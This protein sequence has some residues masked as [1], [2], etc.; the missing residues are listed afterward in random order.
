[1]LPWAQ[2]D[3]AAPWPDARW[4]GIA[5]GDALSEADAERLGGLRARLQALLQ[6]SPLVDGPALLARLRGTALWE[7]QVL[8]HSKVGGHALLAA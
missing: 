6:G 1:L 2:A 5:A 7:E 3:V 8:L 4:P